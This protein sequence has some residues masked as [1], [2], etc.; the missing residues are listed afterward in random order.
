MAGQPRGKRFYTQSGREKEIDRNEKKRKREDIMSKT[1]IITTF[2]TKKN[3]PESSAMDNTQPSEA[4]MNTEILKEEMNKY[5]TE[6]P[7][8]RELIES[9]A[10]VNSTL[11]DACPTLMTKKIAQDPL[12]IDNTQPSGTEINAEILEEQTNNH[13]TQ[14]LDTRELIQSGAEVNPL[15]ADDCENVKNLFYYLNLK[16]V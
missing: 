4:E 13:L 3:A 5:L 1:P 10:D 6:N 14:N 9:G 2:M 8:N 7:D 16:I 12:A 11:I 15:F